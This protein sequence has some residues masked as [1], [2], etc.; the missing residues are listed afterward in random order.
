MVKGIGPVF[1]LTAMDRLVRSVSVGACGPEM[2]VAMVRLQL[3]M[4]PESLGPLSNTYSNH[5]PLGDTPL[6]ATMF[7]A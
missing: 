4:L 1:E 5:S 7:V 6:N 3:L 2:A